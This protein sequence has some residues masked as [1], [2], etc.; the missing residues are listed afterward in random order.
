MKCQYCGFKSTARTMARNR[1]GWYCKA[2]TRC[3]N[4]LFERMRIYRDLYHNCLSAGNAIAQACLHLSNYPKCHIGQEWAS[5]LK[6]L[7]NNWSRS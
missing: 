7:S 1:A 6:S 4:R 2:E 3:F 5:K